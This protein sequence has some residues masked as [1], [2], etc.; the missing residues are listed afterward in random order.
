M[1][2][3]FAMSSSYSIGHVFGIPVRVHITLLIFL[4][5]TPEL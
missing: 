5:G 2:G 3:L 4:I 1:V